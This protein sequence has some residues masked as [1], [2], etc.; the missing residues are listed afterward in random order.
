MRRIKHSKTYQRELEEL[1]AQGIQR[2]GLAVVEEK[3]DRINDTIARF[4]AYNP[5]RPKD[6]YLDIWSYPVT[7]PH[8]SCSTTSTTM[9]CASIASSMSAPIACGLI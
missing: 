5:K 3:R 8:S 9:S 6:R 2:F 7:G 1:L 4:L